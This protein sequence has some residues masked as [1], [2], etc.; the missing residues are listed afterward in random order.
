MP[1]LP[2]YSRSKGAGSAERWMNPAI[3]YTWASGSMPDH[4]QAD[5]EL[6]T[7]LRQVCNNIKSKTDITVY[8]IGFDVLGQPG[9]AERHSGLS[10]APAN[11]RPSTWFHLNQQLRQLLQQSVKVAAPGCQCPV[12]QVGNTHE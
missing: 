9:G 12:G 8:S 3:H 7:R 2:D 11:R 5:L 1:G 4:E 10:T 6:D